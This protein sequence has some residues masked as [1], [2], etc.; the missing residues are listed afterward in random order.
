MDFIEIDLCAKA[1]LR[2]LLHGAAA[3]SPCSEIFESDFIEF[4]LLCEPVE[5]RGGRSDDVALQKGIRFVHCSR[6]LLF[7]FFVEYDVR[8]RRSAETRRI[9]WFTNQTDVVADL[10]RLCR[11]EAMNHLVFAHDTMAHDVDEATCVIRFIEFGITAEVRN[12][13][14][15]PVARDAAGDF[16]CNGP[17]LLRLQIPEPQRIHETNHAG[18]HADN[19]AN[20]SPHARRCAFVGNDLGRMVVA[21]VGND[22]PPSLPLGVIGDSDNAT[23]FFWSQNHMPSFR[24]KHLQKS[25]ARF[26]TAVLRSL[27]SPDHGFYTSG[28]TTE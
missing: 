25:P 17:R 23:I 9:R 3:H 22:N 16:L 10:P 8:K 5:E 28:I 15:I 24:M 13:E 27:Y 14:R 19:I 21:F 18:A 26:I 4:L 6:V 2:H 20:V 7:L 12:A 11:N 1:L